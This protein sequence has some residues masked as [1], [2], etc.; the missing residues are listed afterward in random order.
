M[1]D[2]ELDSLLQLAHAQADAARPLGLQADGTVLC[3]AHAGLH[4]QALAWLEAAAVP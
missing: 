2:A 3:A 4:A 1:T